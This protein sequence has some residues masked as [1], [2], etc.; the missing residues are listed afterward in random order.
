VGL[1]TWVA[2][3]RESPPGLSE[4]AP[5][6][7]AGVAGVIGLAAFYRALALG[8]MGVVAPISSVAPL[9]PLAVDA[10]K[11][12][13]PNAV[14]LAGGALVLAGVVA[15]SQERSSLGR[16]TLATGAALALFAALGFGGFIVGLDAGSDVSA[17]WG[18]LSART[19]ETIVALG[20]AAFTRPPSAQ[21][22]GFFQWSSR[23]GSSTLQR[24]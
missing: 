18:A 4:L 8:A 15:L 24:T 6:A 10:A 2:V 20:A 12:I 17:P 14:Q 21:S 22:S 3:S 19:S 7:G 16:R 1:A 11:G 23:S 13:T 5:A 9:V